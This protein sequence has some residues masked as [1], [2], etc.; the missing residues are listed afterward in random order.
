MQN[1]A[2]SYGQLWSDLVWKIPKLNLHFF[3]RSVPNKLCY[4]RLISTVQ[5]GRCEE[6]LKVVGK[7]GTFTCSLTMLSAA[8]N[9]TA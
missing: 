7:E 1:T 8:Y 3:F 9:C 5:V 4:K 2:L 6:D